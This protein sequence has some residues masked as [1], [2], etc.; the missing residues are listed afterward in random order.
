MLAGQPLTLDNRLRF[1]IHDAL[2][3]ISMFIIPISQSAPHVYLSALPFTPEES[4][5]ARKFHPMLCNAFVV[6]E[7][8]PSQ[9][10][11][12]VFTAEHHKDPVCHTAFSPDGSTFS[13]TSFSAVYIC[14][15]E[16]GHCIS[17][18]SERPGIYDT[19][20]SPAGKHILVKSD[21]H[22]V[23]W[24]VETGEKQYQI[25][26]SDFAFNHHGGR[27]ASVKKDRNLDNSEDKGAN[28]ILVQ[29]WDASNGTLIY[30]RLLE[31]N[32]VRVAQF[33][34]DGHFLA[35][36]KRSEDVI[37]LRNLEDNKEIRRFTYPHR[38]L[39]FIRFS[40]TSDTLM[41]GS[42]EKPRQVYLWRLDTQEMAS[43]SHDFYGVPHV[44]HSPLTNYLF[45]ERLDTV[46]IWDV[47][48]TGSKMICEMKPGSTSLLRSI[49]PSCDG[50]RV[51]VGYYDG[52]VE[53]WNLDLENLAI[54]QADTTDARDVRRVVT[55]SPSGKMVVTGSQQPSK[56]KFLD[57]TTGKVIACTD[58]EYED[59]MEI[60]FS[61]DEEQVAFL[62]K[63]LIIIY[64][65]MHPEKRVLFDPWPG[66]DIRKGR[67]AFQTCNDLVICA[68]SRGYSGTL[69]VWHQQ[70]PTGF[71]CT[72]SLDFKPDKYS[73][74]ILAPDGL[75]AIV[76]YFSSTKYYSWNHETAQFDP[77][78]FEDQ[79]HVLWHPKY[80][81]DGKLFAC[82]S[83]YDSHVRVWDTRTGYLVSKFPTPRVDAIALSPALIDHSLGERL[84]A[85]RFNNENAICL[86]DA[87]TGH[88]H[89]QVLGQAYTD[90]AFI[91]D[92]TVLAYYSSDFGLRVWDIANLAVDLW[93]STH[94][95]ELMLQGMREGW[96]MGRDDE[97]L[98]W[99]PAE[100]R[101]HLCAPPFKVVIKAPQMNSTMPDLSNSRFGRKWTE[102]ID[103]EW[104]RELEKKKKEVGNLLK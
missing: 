61:P 5:V 30:N 49:C 102:C 14:D 71:K 92:G 45:I 25:E 29:F 78:H 38:N 90:M 50:H 104:L 15:S 31:V 7:G 26:G 33:S 21:S 100:H 62:S 73:Y 86:F 95:Y 59:D 39:S 10:P 32:D 12:V 81:P 96:V 17:G 65:I 3:F 94:G 74:P 60:A 8:R 91:R 66:K 83:L 89:A 70:D 37:E 85:L 79:V 55:I 56:V 44:I 99:V 13:S 98:F 18:P 53:M 4:R 16:T 69:Q 57:T 6:T 48:E 88:Q 63:S 22:A 75:T 72:Y 2:R 34:P 93:H 36:A 87:Y 40:P 54:N 1:F 67:V 28:R 68:I 51:L 47:S 103:K 19:C 24:D 46:E 27:I 9:Q 97:P 35:I 11:M 84:I 77:V 101:E 43:F 58:I 80:S 82:R 76:P 41:V 20:F 23:V 64:N 42:R 52:S